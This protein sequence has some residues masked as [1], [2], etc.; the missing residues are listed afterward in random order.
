MEDGNEDE[1][2]ENEDKDEDEN[3]NDEDE[4]G[5]HEDEGGRPKCLI[6]KGLGQLGFPRL[7]NPNL[8]LTVQES[9]FFNFERSM[10]SASRC[11]NCFA[12]TLKV[13]EAN[14]SCLDLVVVAQKLASRPFG[15]EPL[16][17]IGFKGRTLHA[18][19]CVFVGGPS[20]LRFHALWAPVVTPYSEEHR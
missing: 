7:L 2:N 10:I 15:F 12:C 4:D 17:H 16:S 3:E 13:L 1:D 14:K 11:T 20:S 8:T 6:W 9:I 5:D 19:H 18:Q